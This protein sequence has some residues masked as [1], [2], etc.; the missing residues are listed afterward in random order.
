VTYAFFWSPPEICLSRPYAHD[1]SS[2]RLYVLCYICKCS[3]RR[4][5]RLPLAVPSTKIISGPVAE[6]ARPRPGRLADCGMC[7][8]LLFVVYCWRLYLSGVDCFGQ[9]ASG[10]VHAK[11]PGYQS[12]RFRSRRRSSR[13]LTARPAIVESSD[14]LLLP[15]P[16][17]RQSI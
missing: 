7:Q 11:T 16:S 8:R 4:F 3:N 2:R 14:A 5:M 9:C 1:G 15:C 6:H 17:E 12:V 10:L 13:V